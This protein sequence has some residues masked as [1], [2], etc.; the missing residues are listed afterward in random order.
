M[1]DEEFEGWGNYQIDF[2]TELHK[3]LTELHKIHIELQ[4]DI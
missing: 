1:N 2:L 3:I 4:T